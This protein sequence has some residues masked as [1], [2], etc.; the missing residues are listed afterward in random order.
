MTLDPQQQEAVDSRAPV[1]LVAA[2]AGSG[3]TKVLVERIKSLVAGGELEPH[4]IA[5]MTFTNT[6]ARELATRL[7]TIRLGYIGTLH[8]F[9]FRMLQRHGAAVGY[10]AGGINLISEE[11]SDE[12]LAEVAK[13]LSFKGSGKALKEARDPLAQLCHKERDH[14]LKRNNLVNF[15]GVLRDALFLLECCGHVR[16]ELGIKELLVD[17]AQDS[18]LV[19]WE[20]YRVLQTPSRFI[21]GDPDQ[22]IFAFRGAYPKG[23]VDASRGA[24][25]I[26]LETNYRSA[27]AICHAANAL[28]SH[29]SDCIEKTMISH[30]DARGHVSVQRYGT[31]AQERAAIAG[32]IRAAIAAQILGLAAI[33]DALSKGK[34]LR[35]ADLTYADLTY[36]DLTR[37]DLTGA[38]LTGADLAG[39]DLT[40][41]NLTGAY[42]TG[43]YL[44]RA[45][46]TRANL[47]R[48]N[49]T[50]AYLTRADLTRAD[51]TGADLTRADLTGADLAYADLPGANLI[52]A[53]LTGANLT[54]AD[55]ARANLEP[56]RADFLSAVA[57]APHELEFLR[58][59]I[60]A[61][62]IDGSSYSGKCACLAG[63]IAHAK[64]IEGY[65]GG[66]ITNGLTFP[67]DARSPREIFFLAIRRGDTPATS[68]FSAIALAWT[69]EAIAMRDHLVACAKPKKEA[70]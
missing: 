2:S 43:A 7:G 67:V 32:Q 42:L 16:V 45:N 13:A 1:T 17:E 48:A 22:S 3:K 27:I 70:K 52:G 23:F 41:A 50:G 53:N 56:I 39:A 44:T 30:S 28:I 8:G 61:G 11:H 25:L 29:N 9:C 64:G 34:S 51:L 31:C 60:L 66:D 18:A 47:T 40:R 63:T 4:E 33:L 54:R 68:Q 35:G 21:V 65:N 26:R 6:G 14:R 36:A 69:E 49:L 59:A 10:R 15:D 37:A 24:T 57:N 55:L 20:I 58:A 12:L 38:D 46:L 62:R 5:C 19:D